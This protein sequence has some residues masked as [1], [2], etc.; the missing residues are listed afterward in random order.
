MIEHTKRV[1]CLCIQIAA[2][3]SNWLQLQL[4]KYTPKLATQKCHRHK[5]RD[6]VYSVVLWSGCNS[7]ALCELYRLI[8]RSHCNPLLQCA[9]VC[10]CMCAPLSSLRQRLVVVV[11][12]G[13]IKVRGERLS[14]RDKQTHLRAEATLRLRRRR[15]RSLS[16][17]WISTTT[18]I[19]ELSGAHTCKHK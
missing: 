12:V 15:L 4:D 5:E 7:S 10:V 1:C 2:T 13:A 8:S 14:S 3:E 19:S 17:A 11:V 18:S 6:L 9:I 16:A